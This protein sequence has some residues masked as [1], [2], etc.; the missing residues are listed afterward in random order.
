MLVGKRIILN[1]IN[2]GAFKK[3]KSNLM[4]RV[5]TLNHITGNLQLDNGA[6]LA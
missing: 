1:K 4:D 6:L 3:I 5:N 2:K